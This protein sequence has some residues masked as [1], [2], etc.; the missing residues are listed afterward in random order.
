M[1]WQEG[2]V[3]HSRKITEQ[4]IGQFYECLKRE[5]K[6][7]ATIEKY[8][9]DV[10]AF[11]IYAGE[12]V[13]KK[14]LVQRWK[15]KLLDSGYA[16]RS[17]NSMLASLNSLFYFLGWED[18][19]V[20]NLKM[21]RQTYCPEE[22][23]LTKSEYLRLLKAADHKPQLRLIMETLCST[24]IR[25]SEL[26]SF[27]VEA[28]KKGR[29]EISCKGK[30]RTILLPGKLKKYLIDYAKKHQIRT[31]MIFLTKQGTPLHRSSIWAQMKKLCKKAKVRADKVFPHNL[32][33]LFARVF[34]AQEKD[35]AKLADVLGHSSIN[36]TRIYIMTTGA[37]HLR[38]L[39]QMGLVV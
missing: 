13:V 36:T 18:C 23:E 39:N 8:I 16:V 7:R 27:T 9:R 2:N 15:Q 10:R 12:N 6:S 24:G 34:Y 28:V 37:E 32:R 29:V 4:M 11:Y 17:I 33:K 5:E 35:I 20:K 1:I 31:G 19:R 30:I 38:Q 14:E 3:M 21:Q 22:K 25:V 26:H